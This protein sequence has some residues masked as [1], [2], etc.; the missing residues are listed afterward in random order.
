[1]QSLPSPSIRPHILTPSPHNP[2]PH[3]PHLP[4]PPVGNFW[5]RPIQWNGCLTSQ[6]QAQEKPQNMFG[7]GGQHRGVGLFVK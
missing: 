4:S 7:G 5:K 2:L 6:G 3:L 1:M